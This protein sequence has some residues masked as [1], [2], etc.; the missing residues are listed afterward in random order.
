MIHKRLTENMPFIGWLLALLA[1]SAACYEWVGIYPILVLLFVAFFLWVWT[2]QS[3]SKARSSSTMQFKST[4]Q[5]RTIPRS[6][7]KGAVQFHPMPSSNM[8]ITAHLQETG[9]C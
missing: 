2:V 9:L 8:N 4:G 6:F 3:R 5:L 1:V 7:I